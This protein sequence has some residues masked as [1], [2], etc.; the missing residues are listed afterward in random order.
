M[1]L[2]Q[3]IVSAQST[4]ALPYNRLKKNSNGTDAIGYNWAMKNW[5]M[6]LFINH[7]SR[8][9]ICCITCQTASLALADQ[10]VLSN[11]ASLVGKADSAHSDANSTGIT[12]ENGIE[13]SLSVSSVR[14]VV[15]PDE[16]KQFY[17]KNSEKAKDT[18]EAHQTVIN[19]ANKSGLR[20]VA[21]AHYQRLTDLEPDNRAAWAALSYSETSQGWI[22]RDRY[23]QS[24]GLVRESGRWKT[25][26]DVAISKA[27]EE[28]RK[29]SYE[30]QKRIENASRD[31]FSG[32]K[33]AADARVYL[34]Q[35]NDPNAL[36]PLMEQIAASSS[37]EVYRLYL[38]DIVAKL[39]TRA[40]DSALVTLLINDS[41]RGVRDRCIDYLARRRSETAVAKLQSYLVNNDPTQDSAETINRAAEGLSVIGDSRSIPRLIDVLVTKH[42][43][44]ISGGAG[45]NAGFN[46][47]GGIGFTP[48]AGGKLV[49]FESKNNDVLAAL[50]TLS[51]QSF[52]FDKQAWL[53]WY[54]SANAD[55]NLE[56]RRDR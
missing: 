56:L 8:L 54:A 19:W 33:R 5:A 47:N 22:P 28:R 30:I 10:V 24:K 36:R 17:L 32:G 4:F 49:E 39:P 55:L 51:K 27:V 15:A 45:I 38:L 11:G 34:S 18:A 40:V 31:L 41:A 48:N 25:P 6:K 29:S 42:R 2:R 9:L 50:Q 21:Q 23:W 13:I 20:D 52:G 1:I 37:D 14:A 35:L 12:L 16:A 3:L 44:V 53:N 26:Q 7:K 46:G 43:Q